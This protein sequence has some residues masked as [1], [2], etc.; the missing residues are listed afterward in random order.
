MGFSHFLR[1]FLQV[2]HPCRVLTKGVFAE[3]AVGVDISGT[4]VDEPKHRRSCLNSLLEPPSVSW[5][6]D[7]AANKREWVMK[8][9][10]IWCSAR[11][12]L[13]LAMSIIAAPISPL[14]SLA[15]A[16]CIKSPQRQLRKLF[17]ATDTSH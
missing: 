17:N 6:H 10:G 16:E 3:G 14:L 15:Y 11:K 4:L 8:E 2:R 1:R 12:Y 7:V 9:E 5:C 13:R